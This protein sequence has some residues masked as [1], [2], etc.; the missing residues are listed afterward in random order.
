MMM[1]GY[2]LLRTATASLLAASVLLG[3]R[4]PTRAADSPPTAQLGIELPTIGII[5]REFHNR[6]RVSFERYF[7]SQVMKDI[8]DNLHASYVRTGWIPDWIA[9]EQRRHHAWRN[10]DEAMRSICGSGLH[11]MIIVPREGEDAAG[12]QHLLENV[13]FFFARY[14]R[15]EPGCIA[16][17]EIGNETDLPVNGYRDVRSYAAYYAR[18]APIVGSF[19]VRVITSGASGEDRPWTATLAAFLAGLPSPPP[20][21]GF[22]FHPYGVLVSEMGAAVMAMRT[23]A[24]TGSGS[25]PLVYVTEIGQKSPDA[26]Y[27]TLLGL[28]RATP[29]ITIYEYRA[30]PGEDPRFALKEN[31]QLYAAAQNAWTAAFSH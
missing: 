21:A 25:L 13:R 31:P 18:V 24:A 6:W 26:L 5:F 14:T 11:A 17:A 4:Q 23:A 3:G 8:R 27:R 29:A 10:E 7:S 20:V 2:R 22:G 15:R 16:W 1:T 9:R 19:G 12:T 30:Q 28:S